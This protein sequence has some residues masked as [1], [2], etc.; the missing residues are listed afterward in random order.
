MQSSFLH[1]L[2]GRG[3]SGQAAVHADDLS[4]AK[5]LETVRKRLRRLLGSSLG[6]VTSGSAGCHSPPVPPEPGDEVGQSAGILL[7]W[8]HPSVISA[9]SR[10]PAT[11]SPIH[12]GKGPARASGH[13]VVTSERSRSPVRGTVSPLTTPNRRSFCQPTGF[14]RSKRKKPTGWND[15]VVVPPGRLTL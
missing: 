14:A 6:G 2:V 8:V 11:P 12:A 4:V 5:V 7:R 9:R 13:R 10:H 3:G 15:F 1:S